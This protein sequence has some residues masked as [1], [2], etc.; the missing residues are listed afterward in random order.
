MAPRPI[1]DRAMTAAERQQRRRDKLAVQRKQAAERIAAIRPVMEELD[2]RRRAIGQAARFLSGLDDPARLA[3]M[4]VRSGGPM[5][6]HSTLMAAAAW[7]AEFAEA[8]KYAA[9]LATSPA[10]P[11]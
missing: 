4:L 7:L 9:A 5:P 2:R 3:A 11:P 8:M 6:S 1:F 10:P